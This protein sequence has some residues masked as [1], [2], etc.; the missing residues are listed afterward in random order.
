LHALPEVGTDD[1]GVLA[2][3][4]FLLVL[5]FAGVGHIAQKFVQAGFRERLA[6]LPVHN[7]FRTFVARARAQKFSF[8]V[9]PRAEF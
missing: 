5:E 7:H 9:N 4:D 1:R 6:P 3:V 2:L 8:R